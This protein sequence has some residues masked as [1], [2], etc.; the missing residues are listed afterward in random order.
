[1][2]VWNRFMY[3]RSS[4]LLDDRVGKIRTERTVNFHHDIHRRK[5]KERRIIIN[6]SMNKYRLATIKCCQNELRFSLSLSLSHLSM[7]KHI[8][9]IDVLRKI[10]KQK[11]IDKCMR[12]MGVMFLI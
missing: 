8:G 7:L 6:K 12:C 5:K 3:L 11:P 10:E 9:S 1:M 2:S 4:S